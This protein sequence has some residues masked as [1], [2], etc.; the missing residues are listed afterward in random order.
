AAISRKPACSRWR[1]HGS[2]RRPPTRG[3]RSSAGTDAGSVGTAAKKFAG[4]FLRAGHITAVSVFAVVG[5][6]AGKHR[7]HLVEIRR[8]AAA[9]AAAMAQMRTWLDH[10]QTEP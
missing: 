3:I 4:G 2:A 9:L 10:R 1:G 5:P 7:M 6:L 8:P